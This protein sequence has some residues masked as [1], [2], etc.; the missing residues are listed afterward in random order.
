MRKNILKFSLNV[1]CTVSD[2][3]KKIISRWFQAYTS[4]ISSS[5]DLFFLFSPILSDFLTSADAVEDVD[6]ELL[7]VEGFTESEVADCFT[8]R[9]FKGVFFLQ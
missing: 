2:F 7:L 9:L 6:N 5:A 1:N 8:K 4:I 3:L